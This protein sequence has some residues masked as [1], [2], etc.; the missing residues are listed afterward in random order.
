[1]REL[2]RKLLIKRS[3]IMAFYDSI[4]TKADMLIANIQAEFARRAPSLD[5]VGTMVGIFLA[6]LVQEAQ[7]KASAAISGPEKKAAVIAAATALFNTA[8]I[9]V[10]AIPWLPKWLASWLTKYSFPLYL[11]IVSGAIDA[12]V[13]I[14][15][16]NEVK[17]FETEKPQ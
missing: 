17:N 1:V 5:E 15:K 2:E 11:A 16:E 3:R 6:K 12:I 14:L 8:L 9:G 7:E 13:N 10:I 4:K